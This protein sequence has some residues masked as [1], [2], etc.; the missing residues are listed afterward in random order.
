M[1]SWD[2]GS[3]SSTE[4]HTPVR[5]TSST[6]FLR[7]GDYREDRMARQ[8]L[9]RH[10]VIC[11]SSVNLFGKGDEMHASAR[12]SSVITVTLAF[13]LALNSSAIGAE[14]PESRANQSG[15][16]RIAGVEEAV[17]RSFVSGASDHHVLLFAAAR[18]ANEHNASAGLAAALN[19]LVA[20]LMVAGSGPSEGRVPGTP[21]PLAV[22]DLGDEAVSQVIVLSDAADSLGVVTILGVRSDNIVLIGLRMGTNEGDALAPLTSALSASL[23]RLDSATNTPAK[24][25]SSSQTS[26]AQLRTDGLYAVLPR[27]EDV[28]EGFIF[29]ADL[30][31]SLFLGAIDTTTD[32]FFG[33]SPSATPSAAQ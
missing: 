9:P 4:P 5:C 20:N 21:Y 3:T 27:L 7:L 15:D 12:R 28:P 24:P 8:N 29:E 6:T 10:S 2:L 32:V 16:D 31:P 25:S 18:F 1:T 26:E 19:R 23:A 14:T 13:L 11:R 17:S 30:Q 22:S 33:S